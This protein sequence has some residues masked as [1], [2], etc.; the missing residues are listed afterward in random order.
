MCPR[1]IYDP[2]IKEIVLILINYDK[3]GPLQ[4]IG[5]PLLGEAPLIGRLR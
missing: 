4:T 5:V 2:I 1:E 3:T